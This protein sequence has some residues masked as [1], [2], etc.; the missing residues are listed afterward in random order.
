METR[1]CRN[2][3]NCFGCIGMINAKYCIFNKQY[4]ETEYFEMVKKIKQHMDEMPYVDAQGRVF[5]YGEFFPYNMS[6]FGYNE[7]NAQDY[8]NLSKEQALA[9]GYPWR[10]RVKRDY[11][12]TKQAQELPDSINDVDDTILQEV[13]ACPNNGNPDFLC[14][15]AY[16]ITPDELRFYRSKKLPLPHFCPNCR[17]YQRLLS[18]RNPFKLYSRSCTCNQAGHGHEGNRPNT[19]ETSYAP[20]R[21]EKVYCESCYQKAVL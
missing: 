1:N 8:F 15:T 11:A 19:F 21:P 5:K 20:D 17:H 14:T 16:R 12:A 10:D 3:V 7:T 18:Y 2:C 4:T 13:I 6:P 9:K